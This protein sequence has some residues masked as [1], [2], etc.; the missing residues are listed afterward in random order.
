MLSAEIMKDS[1]KYCKNVLRK[2]WQ[3]FIFLPN[4]LVFSFLISLT[5]LSFHSI[6]QVQ[7]FPSCVSD[8]V[9]H[10][11]HHSHNNNSA[12]VCM[13]VSK[14]PLGQQRE[15]SNFWESF[16]FVI[17]FPFPP[18]LHSFV[19]CK[20]P[21]LSSTWSLSSLSSSLSST[22]T[23]TAPTRSLTLNL[24]LLLFTD[25]P[26]H[27]EFCTV[28][29][30]AVYCTWHIL[31]CC[32]CREKKPPSVGFVI[33]KLEDTRMQTFKRSRLLLQESTC[34]REGLSVIMWQ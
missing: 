7:W 8:P 14:F 25:T 12:C 11:F 3:Q 10:S 20:L 29:L 33:R 13:C 17:S 30:P 32:Y 26:L 6:L 16:P 27:V 15:R 31:T 4:E 23:H 9:Y 2:H 21:P 28:T 24:S 5:L 34:L 19:P 18:S 22:K 1:G